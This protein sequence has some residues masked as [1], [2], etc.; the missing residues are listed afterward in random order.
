MARATV[1]LA[2]VLLSFAGAAVAQAE[3][4]I[5]LLIGNQA[6]TPEIG[7]ERM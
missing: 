1:A 4:R 6:Y 2:L 5:G 3:K 7:V